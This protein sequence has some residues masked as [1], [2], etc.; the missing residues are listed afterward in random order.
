MTRVNTE[1]VQ[2]LSTTATKP[3]STGP[4]QTAKRTTASPVVEQAL[5][6]KKPVVPD[7]RS[8]QE[9]TA[10]AAAQIESYLR[11]SGRSLHFSV[12]TQSGETVVS[13]KEAATGDV[14]RQIPSEEALRLA[15]ALQ[16]QGGGSSLLDV[17]V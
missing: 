6:L 5:I 1:K 10:A 15:H 3:A 11:S 4:Q 13:V 17:E 8:V 7:T 2:P 16:A 12:D 14:I 9:V